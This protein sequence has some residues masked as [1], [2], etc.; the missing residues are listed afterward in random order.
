MKIENVDNKWRYGAEH[1]G[2]ADS[3]CSPLTVGRSA[4]KSSTMNTSTEQ[5]EV[6]VSINNPVGR[7]YPIPKN[8]NVDAALSTG[9]MN[10]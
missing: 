8:R 7:L 1:Y 9:T 2:A 5:V 10:E 6:T 3:L 4:A